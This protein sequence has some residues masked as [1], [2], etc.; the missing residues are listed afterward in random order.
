RTILRRH[1][2]TYPTDCAWL[3]E[4]VGRALD[5]EI[6]HTD[7]GWKWRPLPYSWPSGK[8]EWPSERS[9]ANFMCQATGGEMMRIASVLAV[10]AG[11][12]L[13]GT[14]H[15]SLVIC[16]PIAKLCEQSEITRACM[17]KAG[18][19]LTGIKIDI[20]TNTIRWPN[21]YKDPKGRGQSTWDR[22]VSLLD[23]L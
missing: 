21:R 23:E 18:E 3:R 14:F 1:R 5:R 20:E 6:M 11:V 22:T 4:T 8:T 15:D 12:R 7:F 10:R 2:E 17:V 16:A 13:A 9:I 19:A